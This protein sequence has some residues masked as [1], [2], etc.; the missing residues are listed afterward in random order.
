MEVPGKTMRQIFTMALGSVSTKENVYENDLLRHRLKHTCSTFSKVVDQVPALWSFIFLETANDKR[1]FPLDTCK[2]SVDTHISKS[3]T[4]PL[5]IFFDV[6]V[7][8]LKEA[9]SHYIWT[10]LLAV[11]PRWRTFFLTGPAHCGLDGLCVHAL[12]EGL[13]LSSAVNLKILVITKK[14]NLPCSK[15]HET[16]VLASDSLQLACCTIAARIAFTPSTSLQYLHIATHN[17]RQD[18]DWS[19]FFSSCANL[20]QLFWDTKHVLAFSRTIP[21]PS[22]HRLTLWTLE[23]LP[24]IFAP[25][26]AALEILDRS[27]PADMQLISTLAGSAVHLRSLVLHANPVTSASLLD[28]LEKCPH[29]QRLMLSASEPRAPVLHALSRKLG[30]QY[31]TNQRCRLAG[32]VIQGDPKQHDIGDETSAC[33]ELERL[34]HQR[35][36]PRADCTFF[37]PFCKG[38]CVIVTHF[39]YPL[40]TKDVID[41]YSHAHV[42]RRIPFAVSVLKVWATEGDSLGNI[43]QGGTT[44]MILLDLQWKEANFLA[45]LGFEYHG[46]RYKMLCNKSV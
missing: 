44:L 45:A 16:V 21:L 10:A 46:K 1:A 32:I 38:T 20:R 30:S 5:H 31:V 6:P 17:G 3:G 22:L 12:V 27:V 7:G 40:T 25:R 23:F 37:V 13:N 35:T 43:P 36:Y 9:A 11:S 26:L 34:C 42:T 41:A 8:P 14:A 15:K 2:S 24:S 33:L 18:F 29:L 28:I 4:R 39:P 19:P